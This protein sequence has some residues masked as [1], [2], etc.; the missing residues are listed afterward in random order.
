MD[1]PNT[2]QEGLNL[3]V[4]NSYVRSSW[5]AFFSL[6]VLWGLSYFSCHIVDRDTYAEP[7]TEAVGASTATT[8]PKKKGGSQ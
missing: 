3:F 4:R 2:S 5:I 8:P 1:S 6:W 7:D